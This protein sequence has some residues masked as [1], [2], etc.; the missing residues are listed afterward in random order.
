MKFLEHFANPFTKNMMYESSGLVACL[1][2]SPNV[3]LGY[4]IYSPP[5]T[6]HWIHVKPEF[7]G[8]KIARALWLA[9]NLP[10]SAAIAT[11]WHKSVSGAFRRFFI[12]YRPGY[13]YTVGKEE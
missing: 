11:S 8:M 1:Q 10:V 5:K 3:I 9:S 13:C 12:E 4:I 2:D 7:Q 6:V